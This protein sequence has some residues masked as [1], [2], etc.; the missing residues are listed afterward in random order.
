MTILIPSAID[1][2]SSTSLV[3][4]ELHFLTVLAV[5]WY[6]KSIK[7]IQ[8]TVEE[9]L[10]RSWHFRIYKWPVAYSFV[11]SIITQALNL[12]KKSIPHH[13]WFVLKEI[14]RSLHPSLC[15]FLIATS[16]NRYPHQT[17]PENKESIII[18]LKN[19]E[20]NK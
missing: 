8:F 6:S 12:C 3:D 2:Y 7:L 14:L 5:S 1:W 18:S 15:W 10:L 20:V 11:Y 9:K 4:L 17:I 16:T 13:Y 19:K